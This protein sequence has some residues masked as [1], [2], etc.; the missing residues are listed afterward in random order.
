MWGNEPFTVGSSQMIRTQ[1]T[2]YY[3][4]AGDTSIPIHILPHIAEKGISYDNFSLPKHAQYNILQQRNPAIISSLEAGLDAREKQTAF[5]KSNWNLF[6]NWAINHPEFFHQGTDGIYRGVIFTHSKFLQ[7]TF[8]LT[9]KIIN[10]NGLHTIVDTNMQRKYPT[11]TRIDIGEINPSSCPDNCFIS[12]CPDSIIKVNTRLKI[13][14]RKNNF[15]SNLELN[16][17]PKRFRGDTPKN[18]T[19]QY[20]TI[21][22]GG[23][24][25]TKT[26]KLRHRR[27]V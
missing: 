5:G 16:N 12:P 23:R 11:Y 6:I 7:S 15:Y 2:A 10:N 1:E 18:I 26:R 19:N 4:L 24:T 21:K 9:E 8:Q 20:K 25:K 13:N 17:V 22:M 14:T 27:S 3:M